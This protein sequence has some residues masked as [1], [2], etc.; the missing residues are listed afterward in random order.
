MCS[1]PEVAKLSGD[2]R[3]TF[4]ALVTGMLP[5]VESAIDR[6]QATAGAIEVV[7][8]ALDPIRTKLD[9]WSHQPA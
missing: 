5:K 2:A 3:K 1:S 9:D 8:P 7:K 6:V 4:A